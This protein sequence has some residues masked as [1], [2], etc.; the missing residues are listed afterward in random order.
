MVDVLMHHTRSIYWSRLSL[1]KRNYSWTTNLFFQLSKNCTILTKHRLGKIMFFPSSCWI[2]YPLKTWRILCLPFSFDKK[3][4]VGVSV[5]C[6]LQAL[7]VLD[8]NTALRKVDLMCKELS[9]I[10]EMFPYLLN[11]SGKHLNNRELNPMAVERARSIPQDVIHSNQ[12]VSF[13]LLIQTHVASVKVCKCITLGL[14]PYEVE[15]LAA[16]LYEEHTQEESL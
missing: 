1:S 14:L 6:K 16:M 2:F 9:P 8:C 10:P 7:L 15:R 4:W 11:S 12:G 5:N 3:H 13:V